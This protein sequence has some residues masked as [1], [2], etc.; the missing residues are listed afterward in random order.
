[1]HLLQSGVDLSVIRVWLGHEGLNTT[2]IYVEFDMKMKRE[3]LSKKK[4]PQ[5]RRE[6][7]KVLDQKKDLVT[8]L[9]QMK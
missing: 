1:M 5:L 9:T 7:K 2:H 4:P 8:W 6:L 3:A